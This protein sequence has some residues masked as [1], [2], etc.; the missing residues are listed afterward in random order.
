MALLA[1]LAVLAGLGWV[2]ARDDN[3]TPTA[4]TRRRLRR[5]PPAP[6]T[7]PPATT[8]EETQPEGVPAGYTLYED[9]TG[10]SVAVPDGWEPVR[11]GSR[12]DFREPGG[13]RFL[14]VDQTDDPKKT[15]RRTG[16]SRRSR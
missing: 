10:F 3:P 8:P 14:R 6:S 16:S 15:R 1:V 4:T 12:V 11:D 13:S 5:P 2:V 7:S 9:P